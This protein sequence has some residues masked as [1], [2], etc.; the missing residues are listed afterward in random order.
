M[1]YVFRVWSK[2]KQTKHCFI[3]EMSP[4]K[5]VTLDDYPLC[6]ILSFLDSLLI[7]PICD[8]FSWTMP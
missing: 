2:S 1:T 7:E 5:N 3:K 4:L 8:E 6:P